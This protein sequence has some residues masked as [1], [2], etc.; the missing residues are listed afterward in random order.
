[1][2]IPDK[3]VEKFDETRYEAP[4]ELAKDVA[5]DGATIHP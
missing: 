5:A 3:R 2:D 1:M 4:D